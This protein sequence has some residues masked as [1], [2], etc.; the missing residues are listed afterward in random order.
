MDEPE[1]GRAYVVW[2]FVGV[3]AVQLDIGLRPCRQRL[4]LETFVGMNEIAHVFR[5]LETAMSAAF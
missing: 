4:V 1:T 2:G 5:N 3:V